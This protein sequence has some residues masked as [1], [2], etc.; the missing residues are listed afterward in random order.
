MTYPGCD[1]GLWVSQ[2]PPGSRLSQEDSALSANV[3]RAP[4]RGAGIAP[5]ESAYRWSRPTILDQ[6][7]W[8]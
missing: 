2:V 5:R 7:Q 1:Q 8:W 3:A 6:R 4:A